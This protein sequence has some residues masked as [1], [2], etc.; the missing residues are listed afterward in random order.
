MPTPESGTACKLLL[1]ISI[2]Y[3]PLITAHWTVHRLIERPIATSY[4]R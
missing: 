4:V 2:A 1:I 3:S